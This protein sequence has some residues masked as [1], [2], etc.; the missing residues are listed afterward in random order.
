[1]RE[2]IER[3]QGNPLALEIVAPIDGNIAAFFVTLLFKDIRGFANTAVQSSPDSLER[4]SDVLFVIQSEAVTAA[5]QADLMPR[6]LRVELQDALVSARPTIFQS[7]KSSWLTKPNAHQDLDCVGYAQQP[8]HGICHRTIN[9]TSLLC[10]MEQAQIVSTSRSH[11]LLKAQAKTLQRRANTTWC[12]APDM[13]ETARVQGGGRSLSNCCCNCLQQLQA[14]AARVLLMQSICCANWG[15][16]ESSGL[17]KSHD[18]ADLRVNLHGT[19]FL[20]VLTEP[21]YFHPNMW[22]FVRCL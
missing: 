10:L 22:Y 9:W 18:L 4:Q 3:Y 14:I 20:S 1:M 7:E 19:D 8:G 12:T 6:F 21:L 15:R 11:A 17:L 13:P 2:L 5:I 16:S